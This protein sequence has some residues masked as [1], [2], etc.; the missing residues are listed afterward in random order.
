MLLWRLRQFRSKSGRPAIGRLARQ[1]PP[2]PEGR[3]GPLPQPPR[4]DEHLAGTDCRPIKG[5]P[6]CWEL[7][8]PADKVEHRIF[9]YFSSGKE[10][11]MLA[12]CTHKG[13]M[14]DP[15]RRGLVSGQESTYLDDYEI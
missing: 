7:R 6:G 1:T 12:A 11:V 14:Y 4:P 8:W 13:S 5:H 15:P 3:D 9:G 10:F 2:R